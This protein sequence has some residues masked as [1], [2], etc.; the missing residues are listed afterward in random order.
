MIDAAYIAGLADKDESEGED[1]ST[2]KRESDERLK[3]AFANTAMIDPA[4]LADLADKGGVLP[5]CQDVPKEALVSLKEMEAWGYQGG[6]YTV[7]ALIISYPWLDKNHP[8]PHGEQLRQ[9]AFILRAFA[10]QARKYPG[11]RVGVFWDERKRASNP[12]PLLLLSR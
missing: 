11:C 2:P 4:Y 9:L 12:R 7:G 1:D 3:G 10:K 6:R 5:R 8:D